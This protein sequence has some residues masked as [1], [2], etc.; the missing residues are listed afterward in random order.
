M[1]IEMLGLSSPGLFYNISGKWLSNK[2]SGLLSAK[3]GILA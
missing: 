3:A 1:H 2:M